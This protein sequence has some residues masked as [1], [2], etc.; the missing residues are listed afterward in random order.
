MRDIILVISL[1]I[2]W[3]GVGIRRGKIIASTVSK[4]DSMGTTPAWREDRRKDAPTYIIITG[5]TQRA[6]K[7]ISVEELQGLIDVKA[8]G[9]AGTVTNK[10]IMKLNRL[11]EIR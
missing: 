1:S 10:E 4:D 2:I 8:D 7:S 9:F 6:Y 3:Y 11:D 5:S